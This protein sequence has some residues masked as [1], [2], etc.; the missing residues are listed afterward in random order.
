MVKLSLLGT[1]LLVV[2]TLRLNENTEAG[3]WVV[4]F[5]EI[6]DAVTSEFALKLVALF[7]VK[8]PRPMA[9]IP[10]MSILPAVRIVKELLPVKE[11][12]VAV[13]AVIG[14]PS[15]TATF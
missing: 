8:A 7:T 15:V 1:I 12:P 14:I 3:F 6:L 9:T 4:L 11:F 13:D 5:I 2:V 10:P